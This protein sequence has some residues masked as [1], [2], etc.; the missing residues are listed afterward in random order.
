MEGFDSMQNSNESNSQA[1]FK[2]ICKSCCLKASIV[3]TMEFDLATRNYLEL[4]VL[5]VIY[6]RSKS[7]SKIYFTLKIFAVFLMHSEF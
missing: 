7:L 5:A 3:F 6:G 1:I 2:T 4:T